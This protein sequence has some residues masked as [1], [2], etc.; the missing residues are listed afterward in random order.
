MVERGLRNITVISGSCRGALRPLAVAD[1]ALTADAVA[2]RQEIPLQF[3]QEILH[4]LA[5][6]RLD[7]TQR[8]RDGGH[9]LARPAAEISVAEYTGTAAPLQQVWVAL[10][11]NMRDLLE[12][13]TIADVAAS[14]LPR[15]VMTLAN[16]P[17]SWVTRRTR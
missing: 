13:V 3:L 2:V 15:K 8:G 4:E 12:R 11:T 10:R 5:R 17:E 7:S 16:N 9:R 6:D 1:G 14:R